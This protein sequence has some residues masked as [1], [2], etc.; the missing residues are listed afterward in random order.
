M[1]SNHQVAIETASTS[2]SAVKELNEVVGFDE[3]TFIDCDLEIC[4]TNYDRWL[5][6]KVNP[7]TVGTTLRM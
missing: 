6:M 5:S 4:C 1:A 7:L 3:E 2:I